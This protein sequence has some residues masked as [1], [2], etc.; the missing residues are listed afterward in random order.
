LLFC[1][2]NFNICYCK[3]V[4]IMLL[5]LCW[6]C[7]CSLLL[8]WF[9]CF[10]GWLLKTD[11]LLILLLCWL[12]YKVTP[13]SLIKIMFISLCWLTWF[14]KL[15]LFWWVFFY[16]VL[17][18]HSVKCIH[19]SV[20]DDLDWHFVFIKIMLF[21]YSLFCY[22]CNYFSSIDRF[23]KLVLTHF[24]NLFWHVTWLL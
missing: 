9:C 21:L 6:F 5:L 10:V 1:K 20:L 12:I 4:L 7:C 23:S 22:F 16:L 24:L 18:C 15:V 8:C 17:F 2:C 11:E 19:Y 13:S 14:C 3:L